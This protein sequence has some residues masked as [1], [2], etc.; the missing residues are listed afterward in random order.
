MVCISCAISRANSRVYAKAT[1]LGR[2]N[3]NTLGKIM[4]S[5]LKKCRRLITDKDSAYKLFAKNN[6]SKVG[7]TEKGNLPCSEHKRISFKAESLSAEVLWGINE[8]PG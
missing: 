2:T 8:I 7:R 4:K 5:R 6:T 3:A 1:T